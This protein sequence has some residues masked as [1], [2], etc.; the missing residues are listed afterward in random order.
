MEK[1]DIILFDLDG[2]ITDS[3]PGI[4]ASI[5]YVL[6]YFHIQ[7]REEERLQ[8]FLGP[9]LIDCFMQ[10]YHMDEKQANTALLKYREFYT[11]EGMFRLNVYTD[12]EETI[13]KLKEKG[14]TI[15]LA[16]AKPIVYAEQIIE[17]IGFK[18]Y[19]DILC[20]AS[21]DESRNKKKDVIT[22][23][24]D[25]YGLSKEKT[26]MV[27]DRADDIKGAFVNGIEAM[28]VLYGYGSKEELTN[29]GCRYFAQKPQDIIRTIEEQ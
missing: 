10:Y 7:E 17:R 29:A 5:C 4:F 23:A 3:K 11:K 12:I 27:G 14:K 9:P 8:K 25:T 1:K 18:K 28:G 6:D 21:M 22:Y 16:T 26:L 20:G 15:G 2:T 19:F 24:I 13:S